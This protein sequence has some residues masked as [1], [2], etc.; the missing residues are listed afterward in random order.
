[1]KH[2]NN[3]TLPTSPT[4]PSSIGGHRQ[5]AATRARVWMGGL[6]LALL[7]L[8]GCGSDAAVTGSS[9][10]LGSLYTQGN[11]PTA[12]FL[13]EENKAG[14][15]STLRLL[16]VSWG[17]L[18]EVQDVNGAL[19]HR[20]FVIGENIRTDNVDY[21]V[22]SNPITDQ[23]TLRIL[24]PFGSAAYVQALKRAEQNLTP[25]QSKSLSLSEL[26]PFTVVPRNAAIVLRF[27]D[28][29]DPH[30]VNGAWRDNKN[31]LLVASASGQLKSNV[32]RVFT[33]NPVV[34]PYEARVVVDPNH[35]D[36]YDMGS[37]PAF[38]ST[39]VI[40]DLTVSETEAGASDPPL[41]INPLGLPAS[42][43]TL[44]ANVA[45]R[46]PTRL[47]PQVGQ[48]ILLT[49]PGNKPLAFSGN[50]ANDGS[51]PTSDVVRAFR[52]GNGAD[53]NNGF[54]FDDVAPVLIG[55]LTVALEDDDLGDG[56]PGITNLGGGQFLVRQLRFDPALCSSQLKL[57]QD[58]LDQGGTR[59]I[60]LDAQQDGALV[61]NVLLQVVAPIGGSLLLGGAQL[62]TAYDPDFDQAACFVR[63][64]PNPVTPPAQGVSKAAQI[65]LRFSEPMDPARIGAFDSFTLTRRPLVSPALTNFDYVVGRVQPS[66]DLREF[67]FVPVLPMDRSKGTPAG[68]YH[69]TLAGGAA[70]PT[71]LAGN[72]LDLSGFAVEFAL[73]TTEALSTNA[74]VVLRFNTPNEIIFNTQDQSDGWGE[75]RQGQVLFDPSNGRIVPRPVNRFSA[76]ADRTKPVPSVMTPFPQGVQ[77]PLSRLG[78]K[79]Q[80]LW[81]YV[82]VG[83]SLTDE[84]N[85][86]LDVEGLAWAP[87]GGAVV[88]DSYDEFSIRLAHSLW[89]PDEIPDPMT[90]FPVFPLSGLVKTFAG[91][92]ADPIN[93]PGTI[94]HPQE[95]GYTVSP[96]NMITAESGTLMQ[97]FP[98]NRGLPV[99]QWKT[100]TWRDTSLLAK[101]GA[102]G[103]GAVLAIE[104]FIVFGN[105]NPPLTGIPYPPG[106]VASPGVPTVGLPLLMEFRCYP[107]SSALGLNAFD[108][109]LAVNSC[110]R[111]NFRAFST[112]GIS[113]GQEVIRNPD[114]Q[115]QALGGFNPGTGAGT[116][117]LDNSFYIGQM[118][119]VTRISRV[120]S[121]WFETGLVNPKYATPVIE[122]RANE[123]PLGTEVVLAFRGATTVSTGGAGNLNN[124][125]TNPA[126]LD[127]YGNHPTN[128]SAGIP[129]FLGGNSNWS[130]TM[131]GIDTAPFFQFRVTFI[132]NIETNLSPSLSS[133]GFAYFQ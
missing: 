93:D 17:R 67:S 71:D 95:R 104:N 99:S 125:R 78:S 133:L 30:F 36:V 57:G 91:N 38:Y 14:Q 4:Q 9:A 65:F 101:G 42:V 84:T 46:I 86:N 56:V 37:G 98:M 75:Y 47:A 131:S 88:S 48:S 74:G 73:D 12:G 103:P 106:T 11:L 18:V 16:G 43:T 132:S 114:T 7:T 126:N 79:L 72:P 113:A 8:A 81:R 41:G 122:P 76:A 54:L 80:T 64:S 94:V 77:T 31:Q 10:P 6:G 55:S 21:V 59:A 128:G 20:D 27:D 25:I 68:T 3:H 39:R 90:L 61:R 52:S 32:V 60:V 49:N 119:L 40:I 96:S 111:P 109:S 28:I 116:P 100:Y 124:I 13:V 66:S 115:D 2:N 63:F 130:N 123:Q 127:I 105:P 129:T 110:I 15:A 35:G 120:H 23:T 50:G 118:D 51:S 33:G 102:Q 58:V 44:Q 82:D 26:P 45:F 22:S 19:R 69:L 85:I 97:P 70:G 24:H 53:V 121:I 29:L 89:L 62:Q 5:R 87:I 34:Q 112:G 108:I 107:D 92:F 83:F 1:M 117:G